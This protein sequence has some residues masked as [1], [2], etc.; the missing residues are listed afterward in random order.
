RHGPMVLGVCRRLLG[1]SADAED[2]FQA[3]FL[4]FVRKAASIAGREALGGWL[5]GVAY[6]TALEARGRRARRRAKEKQAGEMPEPLVEPDEHLRDLRP[7]L[8][9]ELNRLPDKYGVP[10]IL[11]EL[12]G[13][14]R[15]EAARI[16]G[17][18]EG[19]LSWRLAQAKKML[20]KRLS[21]HGT[22]LS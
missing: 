14:T 2:A 6:R 21:R 16:L 5:H 15:K 8:D 17:L 7:L 22:A 1:D 9:Q 11:C 3:A 20:A 13:K 10:V 12:E 18:P 4:V 19:T